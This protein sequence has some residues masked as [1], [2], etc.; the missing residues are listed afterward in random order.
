M[1]R[2][3][4][5]VF[6]RSPPSPSISVNSSLSSSRPSTSSPLTMNTRFSLRTRC[7]FLLPNYRPSCL[8][9]LRLRALLFSLPGMNFAL[10]LAVTGRERLI[11][12][13]MC[14]LTPR[15]MET[16]PADCTR[17]SHAPQ[18]LFLPKSERTSHALATVS[19]SSPH[20]LRRLG[21]CDLAL[22]IVFIPDIWHQP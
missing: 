10:R 19:L 21:D 5:R 8:L 15:P 11:S 20:K 2:M 6:L 13:R 16:R 3:K 9:P 18:H 17:P 1:C 22:F 7:T 4:R 14:S 12:P